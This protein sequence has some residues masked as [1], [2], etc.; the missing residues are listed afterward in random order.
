[1]RVAEL[2]MRNSSSQC[3]SGLREVEHSGHRLCEKDI[4]DDENRGGCSQVL[5]KTNVS[6]SQV[7]SKIIAYQFGS[8]DSFGL[9]PPSKKT[10]EEGYLDGVSLTYSTNPRKHIWSFA[11][12]LD[13][14]GTIPYN[15]CPCT[16]ISL[17]A[18]A[19]TPNFIKN[20]DTGNK[21]S[22]RSNHL[23]ANDP[24][25]D[26]AGCRPDNTCCSLNNPPWFFKQ[27]QSFTSEDIEM[28]V[29]CNQGRYD[30]N[31]LVEQIEIFLRCIDVTLWI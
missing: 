24:L 31:L 22:F 3:P 27:L 5:F 11:A 16:N 13:E 6:Y 14:I 1:M 17:A 12:G 10:I 21:N 2:D 8:P 19:T 18:K 7:C 9:H 4:I 20:S 30:E 15:N 26:G 23:Y 28:R 29:C 25:W